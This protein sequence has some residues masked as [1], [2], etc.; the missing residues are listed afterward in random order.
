MITFLVLS[1]LL[2][3]ASAAQG[4]EGVYQVIVKKQQEKQSQRWTLLDWLGTKK[5][6]A[7]MD[8]WLAQNSSSSSLFEFSLQASKGDIDY[9]DGSSER[10]K[11]FERYGASLYMRFFGLSYVSERIGSELSSKNIQANLILLGSS[12]QST[13]IQLFYGLRNLDYLDQSF[14][15][16]FWGARANLYILP[17]LGAHYEYRKYASSSE[18]AMTLNSG[19]R[20]EYGGFV[21]LWLLRLK[22]TF[23]R[24][25]LNFNGGAVAGRPRW[26]GVVFGGEAFF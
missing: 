18:G 2:S 20:H 23:L 12:N 6:M 19:D 14:S 9:N 10:E 8:Q 1:L 7:L 16:S 26:S 17:F 21:E 4:I 24:E 25:R 22:A 13:N 5:K 15:P 3:I 11:A